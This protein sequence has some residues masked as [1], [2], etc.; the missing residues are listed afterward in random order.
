MGHNKSGVIRKKRLK[1]QKKN[2]FKKLNPN[3]FKPKK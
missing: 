2:E 3:F 1:I